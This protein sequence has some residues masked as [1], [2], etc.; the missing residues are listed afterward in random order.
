MRQ[1]LEEIRERVREHGIRPVAVLVW[2]VLRDR[3][4]PPWNLLYWIPVAEGKSVSMP[5]GAEFVM[6]S[7]RSKDLTPLQQ[8]AL[9]RSFAADLMLA[10]QRLARGAALHILFVD[11]RLAGTLFTVTGKTQRFQHILLT[12]R[13]AMV[14]DA[15]IVPAF[16]GKGLY[17]VLLARSVEALRAAQLERLYIETAE[18]NTASLRSY[19]KVGF[20]YLGRHRPLGRERYRYSDR[21]L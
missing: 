20:R 8:E 18:T 10:D 15:R 19:D 16:R 17:P 2:R 13:D 11:G 12:E 7:D 3:I 1:R 6:I 4:R 9:N 21:P 5:P 14:L